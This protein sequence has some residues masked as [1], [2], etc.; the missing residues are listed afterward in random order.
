MRARIDG[1]LVRL[2]ACPL[3][4]ARA[5]RKLEQLRQID[6]FVQMQSASESEAGQSFCPRARKVIS[7]G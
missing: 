4:A 5:A 2:Q 7:G 1:A 3:L 6:A